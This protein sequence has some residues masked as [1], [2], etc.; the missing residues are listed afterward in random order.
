M[1]EKPWEIIFG[2]T[3]RVCAAMQ[4]FIPTIQ[5]IKEKPASA[6]DV[7]I[8]ESWVRICSWLQSLAV[9]NSPAHM[10]CSCGCA[11]SMLEL[12]VD[13]KL[14]I[15]EPDLAERFVRF[16]R[17]NRFEQALKLQKQFGDKIPE[18]ARALLLDDSL[19]QEYER[20]TDEFFTSGSTTNWSGLSIYDRF[21]R[22]GMSKEY[23]TS[24]HYYCTNVHAG[25]IGEST[26]MSQAVDC[27]YC[28]AHNMAHGYFW[29]ASD[30][31]LNA[32]KPPD[33]S[34]TLQAF[35]LQIQGV[36]TEMNRALKVLDEN[37]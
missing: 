26:E 5:G 21:E 19:K 11:R 15:K 1:S 23:R 35:E 7:G 13:I 6:A 28:Y 31:A 27:E 18:S 22:V 37:R 29:E 2:N 32:L 14:L 30:L 4:V 34:Q 17:L 36:A 24:Y 33:W 25:P 9:L 16:E 3:Q 12:L 8:F 20:I 10:Q